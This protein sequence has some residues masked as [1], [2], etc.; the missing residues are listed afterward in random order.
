MKIT[1]YIASFIILVIFFN[2]FINEDSA[3]KTGAIK[4]SNA[5]KINTAISKHNQQDG[6]GF[7][8]RTLVIDKTKSYH[9]QVIQD[10]LADDHVVPK[11]PDIHPVTTMYN[12]EAVIPPQC[13]TK[14]EGVHNPCYVCHQDPIK[15]RENVMADGDLQEA[16]SF[17]DTGLTNH[18]KNL[19]IDRSDKV[20]KISDADI[21]AWIAQDNYSSLAPRL[22]SAKFEGWIPDLADLQLAEKAFD[23]EGFAKD[24]SQWVAFNYKPLPSTFWPTNGSTDDAMIRLPAIFRQDKRG[25]YSK[26]VY[27]ANLAI[28]EATI[29]GVEKI[30]SLQI[31]ENKV[32]VDLNRDGKLSSINQITQV[33]SYVGAAKDEY[34]D[35]YIYPKG[36]EFLHTV[37]Y[38]GI[39]ENGEL[40]NPQRMK[41]VRYMKKWQVFAKPA[42]ARQYQLEGYEKEAG[43]LPGYHH[44]KH[45][46]L[47]NGMA[48]SLQGF[49]EDK[50][51]KL[52]FN[53]YEENFFCM[54]CHNSVGTTID[55]VF[56]FARKVDGANG[57]GYI[58]LKGMPDAPNVGEQQGEILTY[59][60]RVG[61]GGEF[62]SNPEMAERWLDNNGK[63]KTDKILAAK[64]VHELITPSFKRAMQLNKAYKVIVEEQS[65]IF[66]RDATVTPPQNVY[67]QVD[68]QTS[69][70][71][72]AENIYQWDIRLD[73][74]A[75]P[76]P[77]VNE[78]DVA[79]I[80]QKNKQKQ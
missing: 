57:W 73:W 33:G 16:Y 55:K 39:D 17:S 37:R 38:V 62:R 46:G 56:S 75:K 20:A 74:N 4:N 78:K 11:V 64:D 65:F 36:V 14:T 54:G 67:H 6:S 9:N 47:D 22:Q 41:E 45:H 40:Y 72:K 59:L 71:L 49:I 26:D 8:Q 79:S 10:L 50:Q 29:K 30:S 18:W 35:T 48:W 68:N 5:L 80:L 42:L 51:G 24:G 1:I 77:Q 43:H 58:N 44:L 27:K 23:D 52:R 61:G 2:L 12:R 60:H 3:L 15:G 66:G 31:D 34:H 19:F 63:P 32:G 7:K 53:T 13:Y 69:P 25:N 76:K 70:T 21:Q 28:L